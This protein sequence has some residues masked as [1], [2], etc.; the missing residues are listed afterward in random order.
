MIPGHG[1]TGSKSFVPAR[2][3]SFRKENLSDNE[4]RRSKKILALSLA[5]SL[6]RTMPREKAANE[7]KG[8]NRTQAICYNEN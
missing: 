2:E 7:L 6:K 3:E 5:R 4:R 8:K 1:K